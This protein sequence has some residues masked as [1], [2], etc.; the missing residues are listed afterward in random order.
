MKI[1]MRVKHEPLVTGD[2][3]KELGVIVSKDFLM[4]KLKVKPLF[5]TKTSAY[6]DDIPLIRRRLGAYFTRTAKL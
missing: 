1:E 5:E 3:S 4:K 2:L 6:W